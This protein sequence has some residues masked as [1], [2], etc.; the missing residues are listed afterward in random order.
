MIKSVTSMAVVVA[1]SAM[2][3]ACG[4]GPSKNESYQGV[5]HNGQSC[6][7][8]YSNQANQ[9]KCIQQDGRGGGR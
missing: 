2:L 3:V 5:P 8:F 6:K 9:A 4:D 1:L 7:E